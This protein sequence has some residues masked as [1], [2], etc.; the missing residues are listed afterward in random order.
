VVRVEILE[1]GRARLSSFH[2]VGHAGWAAS[3][4][5]IVCAAVSTVLQTAWM[6]LLEV[7]HVAVAAEQTPDALRLTWPEATRDA[8]DVRAIVHTAALA[9]ER[10][11]LQFPQHVGAFRTRHQV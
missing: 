7:A 1:D 9:V 5:D 4:D 10:L 8:A 6:G 2:A 11:A 3:G